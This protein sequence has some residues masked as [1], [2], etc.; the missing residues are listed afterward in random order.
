MSV[1]VSQPIV[2]VLRSVLNQYRILILASV[3]LAFVA[4]IGVY[5]SIKATEET[6][7]L[8]LER[9]SEVLEKSFNSLLERTYKNME[10][11]AT[12]VSNNHD[13]QQLF[14]K[15]MLAVQAEGGGAGA[16]SAAFYRHAL[17]DAVAPSWKKIQQRFDARQ[18]HFHLAPGSLSFLRVHRPEKYGDR[19]D[20]IRHTV[21]DVNASL[22][23]VLGFETGRVYSGLRGVVPV[24]SEDSETQQQVHVGAL[25]VGTSFNTVLKIFDE[26]Q[27][28]G[29][30]ILLRRDHITATMWPEYI[31]ERFGDVIH[32]CGCYL[33]AESRKG[34]L[35][36]MMDLQAEDNENHHRVGL[37]PLGE[38]YYGFSLIPLFDYKKSLSNKDPQNRIGYIAFWFDQ[39]EKYQHLQSTQKR[40]LV[41]GVVGF[42]FVLSMMILLVRFYI[43]HLSIQV[44]QKT[45]ALQESTD[46][47]NQAQ[48][49]AHLGYWQLQ[50]EAN[51]LVFS[52]EVYRIVGLPQGTDI[53]LEQFL[54]CVYEEDQEEVRQTF[55]SAK[56]G[57]SGDLTHRVESKN[58]HLI[59]VRNH[60]EVIFNDAGA[61]DRI[62]GTLQDISHQIELQKAI[63]AKEQLY[64]QIFERSRAVK[65]LVNP[66]QGQIIDANEAA[67]RYYGYSH[68][69]LTSMGI[70]EINTLSLEA[71]RAEFYRTQTENCD[72]GSYKHRLANG[73]IR[74]VEVYTSDVEFDGKHYYHSII[75]DVTERNQVLAQ[76]EKAAMH[77]SLTGLFNR[78]SINYR[79]EPEIA[80]YLR[81]EEPFSVIMM[82]IDYFKRFNDIY[83]H[84]VG[85]LVLKH[86]AQLF[87][88][89]VR[90]TDL[91]GRFGGEEFIVLAPQ[92]NKED[93]IVL[94]ERI[95][96]SVRAFEMEYGDER[97]KI[98]LSAGVA[99]LG[100]SLCLNQTFDLKDC[101]AQLV[102]HADEQLYNAKSK[103]R[104]QVCSF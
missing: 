28:V 86:V 68:K 47:L 27:N 69:Q 73:E 20:N 82:D 76:L 1:P 58:G 66:E 41:L 99:T 60:M 54:S 104:D 36:R 9:D 90:A 11:I 79:A 42:L 5:Y 61:V 83:G 94:A 10:M 49:I 31:E 23:P 59:Y 51:Q 92:T 18:L 35:R 17:Y 53:S 44:E 6:F 37:Y 15:G 74:D 16:E 80:R 45:L 65:L 19:M 91:V 93:A 70:E 29:A 26:T 87:E 102:K 89:E 78:R 43:R 12:F 25:E 3:L 67:Q 24:F 64:R 33:E 75:F 96:S 39:T 22:E 7:Y 98:T 46:Q 30:G 40:Y 72:Y 97:L 56:K 88:S 77:D 52:D 34:E 84:D 100:E 103:G 13:V 71:L 57:I 8:S 4:I 50:V 95:V 85:D 81:T 62:L 55:L 14:Y 32:S 2:P 21:V 101:F 48:K 38:R 63:E